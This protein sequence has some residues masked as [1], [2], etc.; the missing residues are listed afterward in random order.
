MTTNAG[1]S[2]PPQGDTKGTPLPGLLA[3]LLHRYLPV[4]RTVYALLGQVVTLRQQLAEAQAVSA[5]LQQQLNEH[6]EHIQQQL[7]E[8]REHIQQQLNEHREHTRQ[9][10]DEACLRTDDA[11][12]LILASGERLEDLRSRVQLDRRRSGQSDADLTM[13]DDW[14]QDLQEL[15]RGAPEAVLDA[16]KSYVAHFNDR[17]WLRAAGPVI[18][19]GCGRGEWLSLMAEEGWTVKGVDSSEHAVNEARERGLDVELGDLV[20]FL[21]A[22]PENTL[23]GVT[24]FQVIEHLPFGR[25]TA[26]MHAAYRA[27]IPGGMLIL[28][29]PNPENLQVAS[30]GFWLDPTHHHPIPPPL[31]MDLSYHVGFR[32]GSVLRKNPWPQ[33]KE[34]EAETSLESEVAYRLYGP[35]DYSTLV[36]KPTGAEQ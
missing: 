24:A 2:S 12:Q 3:S 21:E 30:Y 13:L 29:T 27:L 28:E 36:C 11:H 8:H 9:R 15:H 32:D 31:I 22:S 10:I 34:Q 23:A 1:G 18:D 26:L 5:H 35:Q 4:W 14:Y 20:D 25:I 16:Q 33:W 17:S 6:R 7:N 19:L